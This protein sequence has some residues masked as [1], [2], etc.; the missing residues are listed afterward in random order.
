MLVSDSISKANA[1]FEEKLKKLQE[2]QAAKIA[3]LEA[4][5]LEPKIVK[6]RT[7]R[8][9]KEKVYRTGRIISASGVRCDL[10]IVDDFHKKANYFY[11]M[12]D[13]FMA[14]TQMIYS[15]FRCGKITEPEYR[16]ILSRYE[17]VKN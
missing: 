13:D 17:A 1:K 15:W 11:E 10:D 8:A 6:E 12:S 5:A 7:S 14:T 9:P 2:K 3:A 4:K 16:T